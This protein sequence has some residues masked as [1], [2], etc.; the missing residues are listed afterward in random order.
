[1]KKFFALILTLCLLLCP[2]A[3]CAG[4]ADPGSPSKGEN[5][6][7]STPGAGSE[8]SRTEESMNT[9]SPSPADAAEGALWSVS[10]REL[11]G[12]PVMARNIAF[13]GDG[14]VY[15]IL[16]EVNEYNIDITRP[17]L[18]SFDPAAGEVIPVGWDADYVRR[19]TV[20]ED[21][22]IGALADPGD[23]PRMMRFRLGSEVTDVSPVIPDS[24]AEVAV[25]PGYDAY[26]Y[27]ETQTGD[28]LLYR[29]ATEETTLIYAGDGEG[30]RKSLVCYLSPGG[31]YVVYIKFVDGLLD[32]DTAYLYDAETGEETAY[33]LPTVE[34]DV[35]SSRY[36]AGIGDT[37]YFFEN[38]SGKE[39]LTNRCWRVRNGGELEELAL[40]FQYRN[41]SGPIE[42][43][44][45]AIFTDRNYDVKQTEASPIYL[46]DA[47]GTAYVADYQLPAKH[48][49]AAA[50]VSGDRLV[51]SVYEGGRDV[52]DWVYYLIETG[53]SEIG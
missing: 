35:R 22:R 17:Y 9:E 13:A 4:Q 15:A 42:T 25:A 31:R 34:S 19:F 43:A 27:N 36:T 40:P 26:C 7:D 23:G 48:W 50:A 24:G 2:C 51:L 1:M 44:D 14:V 20:L 8:A 3:G 10:L 39:E 41:G 29:C 12:K 46:L 16:E 18:V 49:L 45:A 47:D 37:V 5:A 28:L 53:F 30:K 32:N 6:G 21:G 38:D 52:G 33:P 11:M